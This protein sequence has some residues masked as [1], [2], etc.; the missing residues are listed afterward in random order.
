MEGFIEQ[1]VKRDKTAKSLIIKIMSV[2]LL[3][4]IPSVFVSIAPF[5]NCYLA[6]VGFFLF[7]G[8]IYI[9]WYVFSQQK[10]EYEYSV[11]GD[12]LNVAKII[13]LRK[14]KRVCRLE[15]KDIEIL[16]KGDDKVK[17]MHFRKVYEA[18]KDV[19]NTKENYYAVFNEIAY[20]KCLL[21]FNPNDTVLQAMKPY[22]E[23]NIMFKL[24]YGK[25]SHGTD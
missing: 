8:G 13:D 21:I 6:L 7:V 23:K 4:A 22:L 9:V 12:V 5:T 18:A 10:V 1:V 11:T 3:F 25:Q 24:F 14:R 19:G 2:I 15:I 16:D 20:G 17:A